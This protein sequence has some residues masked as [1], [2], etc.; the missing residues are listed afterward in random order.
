MRR[1]PFAP[2]AALAALAAV[3]ATP[4]AAEANPTTSHPS[5]FTSIM[6]NGWSTAPGGD[7]L[8]L[9][10]NTRDIYRVEL[11]PGTHAH[12]APGE[13]LVN[14]VRGSNWICSAIDLDL[15]ISD[16]HG[17]RRSLIATSMRKLTPVEIAAIP[18]KDLP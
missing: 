8:Y 2:L 16:D 1:L 4:A 15:A 12:R 6:W 18:R 17:F 13:F 5:C 14:E 10:I 3:S 11:S 9:R 7:A